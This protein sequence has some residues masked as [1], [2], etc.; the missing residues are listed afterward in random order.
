MFPENLVYFPWFSCPNEDDFLGAFFSRKKPSI[1][2]EILQKSSR[3][4]RRSNPP[5]APLQRCWAMDRWSPGGPKDM[6]AAKWCES[7]RCHWLWWVFMFFLVVISGWFQ[8]ES[9]WLMIIDDDQLNQL[10]INEMN[11]DSWLMMIIW[12]IDNSGVSFLGGDRTARVYAGICCLYLG[13]CG[14]QPTTMVKNGSYWSTLLNSSW[15]IRAIHGDYWTYLS[16]G[17][18][19]F[20]GFNFA[21]RAHGNRWFM[22]LPAVAMA[23]EDTLR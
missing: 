17:E 16:Y 1:P 15:W 6:A 2:P 19:D 3:N 5:S 8:G 20:W 7:R 13:K 12:I 22:I 18:S 21:N 9:W 14:C 10:L 23:M 4:F 11:G